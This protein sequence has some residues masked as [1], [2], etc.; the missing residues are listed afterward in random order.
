MNET[1]LTR[2]SQ[3]TEKMSEAE[4]YLIRYI[5]ENLNT[6]PKLSIVRLS[7][8]ANVST[9][10]IVR[11]MKKLGYNGFTDFK[12]RLKDE[13]DQNPNFSII[14]QVD[15]EIKD[16]ILKNEQEVMRT[17]EML[18]SGLIEDTVQ[19]IRHSKRVILFARGFSELIAKEMEVKL[20]LLNKYAELHDDPNIIRTKS[21][22]LEEGDLVIF[23]SLNGYTE[24]LVDA[25]KSCQQNDTSMIAL[26]CNK[27]SPLASLAELTLTGYK[28]ETS[29]FPDYEVRSRLPLQVISRILLDAYA[30][31]AGK[32]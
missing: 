13:N 20:Q 23:V 6:I 31:R 22:R 21:K 14:E 17:I 3:H 32:S 25:A 26:T 4:L 27:N 18:N 29:Y 10:T 11:T 9:A 8:D 12:I 16:A 5:R 1:F 15:E 30:I 7:E 2:V 24:E 28:S 19:K